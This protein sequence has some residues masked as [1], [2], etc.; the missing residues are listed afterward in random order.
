[1]SKYVFIGGAGRLNLIKIAGV[2]SVCD[3][4]GLGVIYSGTYLCDLMFNLLYID[5]VRRKA[6]PVVGTL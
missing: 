1:M 4:A 5:L 2:R 6:V 3:G